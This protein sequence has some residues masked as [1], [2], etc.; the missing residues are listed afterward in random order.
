LWL[1][2]E[3]HPCCLPEKGR[4]VLTSPLGAMGNPSLGSPIMVHCRSSGP[5]WVGPMMTAPEPS[6]RGE[7]LR[8]SNWSL[9]KSRFPKQMVSPREKPSRDKCLPPAAVTN[10]DDG[11]IRTS[12]GKARCKSPFQACQWPVFFAPVRYRVVKITCSYSKVVMRTMENYKSHYSLSCFSTCYEV[13]ALRP[14]LLLLKKM[15]NVTIEVS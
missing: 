15:S 3:E 13:I 5:P 6:P 1:K 9:M 8:P 4:S 7:R 12:R 11:T 2:W 10:T 14:A